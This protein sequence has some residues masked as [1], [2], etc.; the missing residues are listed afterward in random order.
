MITFV[1]TT[2]HATPDNDERE[3]VWGTM[4]GMKKQYDPI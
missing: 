4:L 1:P 2:L 3:W